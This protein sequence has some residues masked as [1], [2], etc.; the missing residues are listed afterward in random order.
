MIHLD[1]LQTLNLAI[2]VLF[3][4][5][6]LN[7]RVELLRRYNI[8]EPVSGGI[9]VALATYAGYVWLGVETVFDLSSRDELLVMFFTTIGLNARLSD[10]VAGGRMLVILLAM[11]TAFIF[12]A[13][14]DRADRRITLR[15]SRTGRRPGW[16]G[17]ID[18][19]AWDRDCVGTDYPGPNRLPGS[20]RDR[21]RRGDVR[22]HRCCTDRGTDREDPY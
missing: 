6:F 18:R 4:G 1:A 17:V 2:L 20:Q 7:N 21:H 3:A 22:P 10:L 14:H 11:T 16:I 13:E 9:A 12:F 8:P 15:F 19:G 5:K